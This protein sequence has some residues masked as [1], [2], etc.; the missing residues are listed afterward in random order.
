[1]FKSAYGPHCLSKTFVLKTVLKTMLEMIKGIM[2]F[3]II[4]ECYLHTQIFDN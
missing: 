4:K 3:Y 1:M 2:E